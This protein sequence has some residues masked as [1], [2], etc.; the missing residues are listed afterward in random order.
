MALLKVAQLGNPVLRQTA[1]PVPPELIGKAE[2]MRLVTDMVETMR[3]YEGVGLAAPQIH[4][5]LQLIV[6]EAAGERADRGEIPLTVLINPS[7][8][9]AS[10][11]V[12]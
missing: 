8:V 6:I 9:E 12:K 1:K 10:E 3:E 5:P 4:L 2:L 11:D 7:V